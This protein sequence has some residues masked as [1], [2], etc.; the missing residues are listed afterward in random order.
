LNIHNCENGFDINGSVAVRDSYIHDLYQ[1]GDAHT[2][3]I[4]LA[5]GSDITIEH[6]TIF[7]NNGT[8]AIISHPSE[9]SDVLVANNLL[10]GGAY[11][12]YCPRDASRNFRVIGNRFATLFYPKSGAFG[13]WTD[14]EKVAER[15]D[16]VWDDTLDPL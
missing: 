10:A 14:C 9:N 5:G 1:G 13:P 15:R 4:Q 12:L 6:N 3:G 16:N 11:T 2:D 7:D 8:S